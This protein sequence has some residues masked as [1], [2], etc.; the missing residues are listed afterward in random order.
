MASCP[1]TGVPV[2]SNVSTCN[3]YYL[4]TVNERNGILGMTL[5]LKL[6]NETITL[7]DQVMINNAP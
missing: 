1:T 7:Y 3:F 6:N 5:A 2:V 4:P